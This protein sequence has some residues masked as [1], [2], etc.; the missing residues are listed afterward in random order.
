MMSGSRGDILKVRFTTETGSTYL[1]DDREMTWTREAT[2]PDS[3][4]IRGEQT[5]KL[6]EWPKR[7]EVGYSCRMVCPAFTQAA[8]WREI[9]TS[10]ITTVALAYG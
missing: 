1:L 10:H 7:I 3:G 6:L 4:R 9:I 5:G 8:D 2:S